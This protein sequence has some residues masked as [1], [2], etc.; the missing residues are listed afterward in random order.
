[1]SDKDFDSF[2]L[3]LEAEG[4]F[5]DFVTEARRAREGEAEKDRSL[6]STHEAWLATK[7]QLKEALDVLGHLV[8]FYEIPRVVTPIVMK[9]AL[10]R[11]TGLLKKAGRR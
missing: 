3:G 8:G 6:V 2:A 5:A 7:A 1:M 4:G 9:P 11:A 10:E